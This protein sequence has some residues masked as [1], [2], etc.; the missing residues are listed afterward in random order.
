MYMDCCTNRKK[1]FTGHHSDHNWG[2]NE[3]CS[4][5][6]IMLLRKSL[7]LWR[8]ESRWCS[9]WAHTYSNICPTS[10]HR[11][12]SL[13]CTGSW[14]VYMVATIPYFLSS[15]QNKFFP[16]LVLHQHFLFMHCFSLSF[17]PFVYILHFNFILPFSF[18]FPFFWHFPVLPFSNFSTND[19]GAYF[20][21]R[22]YFHRFTIG[23]EK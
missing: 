9:R 1:T 16:H 12:S 7:V 19:T 17:V 15:S 2:E 11:M 6:L 3:N 10:T 21:F 20:H 13:L 18:H 8:T 22:T 23:N 5:Y 4:E 14:R